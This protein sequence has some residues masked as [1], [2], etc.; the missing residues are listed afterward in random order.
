M[1]TRRDTSAKVLTGLD[2]RLEEFVGQPYSPSLPVEPVNPEDFDSEEG[3]VVHETIEPTILHNGRV[4]MRGK[5]V[6][7]KGQ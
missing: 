5:A 7:A 6:L 3:L 1:G 4:L 2:I